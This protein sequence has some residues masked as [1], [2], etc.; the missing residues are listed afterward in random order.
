MASDIAYCRVCGYE[1]TDP[2]PW[3]PGGDLASFEICPCCE[4]EWGYE[5][6]K[7]EGV[8]AYRAKWLAGGAKW[9]N[10]HVP[11]DGLTTEERLAHVPEAYR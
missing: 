6:S 7:P 4:V 5:D 9:S 3:G 1:S 8:R 10:E 2:L 11:E